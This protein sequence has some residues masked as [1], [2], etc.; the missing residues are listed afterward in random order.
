MCLIANTVAA[1]H[2]LTSYLFPSSSP[3]TFIQCSAPL[4]EKEVLNLVLTARQLLQCSEGASCGRWLPTP[5]KVTVEGGGPRNISFS[6]FAAAKL[7]KKSAVKKA[8][9]IL[10]SIVCCCSNGAVARAANLSDLQFHSS[11]KT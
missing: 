11:Q 10:V 2:I 6:T 7:S 8:E 1:Q 9:Y 3:S 4:P 5:P